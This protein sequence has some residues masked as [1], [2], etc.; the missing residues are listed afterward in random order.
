MESITRLFDIVDALRRDDNKK[1]LLNFKVNKQWQSFSA[2]TVAQHIDAVSNALLGKGLHPGDSIGIM[3][4]SRPEWNFV[5]FGIQQ[6]GMVSIPLFPT[7]GLSD[8]KFILQHAEV[9]LLFVG[10]AA[11]YR[12]IAE[13]K[14]EIPSLQF[15]VSFSPIDQCENFQTFIS[16]G[17]DRIR[18]VLVDQLKKIVKE[19]DLFTIIYTSG[20][21]GQPKGVM[22]SHKNILSNIRSLHSLA[23]INSEWR[24]LSFLPLNHVYERVVVLLYFFKGVSIYYAENFET[25]AENCREIRPQIFVAV[26]RLLERVQEKLYAGGDKLTGIKKKIYQLSLRF[27]ENYQPQGKQNLFSALMQKFFDRLVYSKWRAVFGNELVCIVSGGAALNPRLERIFACAGFVLLQGYGM[28]ETAVVIAV[29]TYNPAD[30]LIGTVGPVL[31]GVTVRLAEEDGEVLVKGDN[32]MLGYYKNAAAT[33]E[34]IDGDGYLHTGDVGA[35][36]EGRFLKITDRKKE[37]FKISSGKYVSPVMLENKLKECKFIEQCMVVG[38]GQKFASALIVPD[39]MNYKGYCE[40]KG[41]TWLGNEDMLRHDGLQKLI[42]DHVKEMNKVHAPYEHLKRCKIV[43][44][45][46]TVEGG[47][48]TPKLSLRRKAILQKHQ[49]EMA[50]IYAGDRSA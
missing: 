4:A 6:C 25:I 5:D 40:A 43:M 11:I 1:D 7:I 3:S 16:T 10:D 28:T 41:I 9:K 42:N 32:V 14:E 38:E 15:I 37:I 21:T 47:D 13:L 20:T 39:L 24:A 34:V 36:V 12:K 49:A 44:G 30:R 35:F 48:I 17:Q 23:P 45:K 27:A 19:D 31:S 50:E 8:L 26:P 33:L 18:T 22:I 29:T 2:E 46:W